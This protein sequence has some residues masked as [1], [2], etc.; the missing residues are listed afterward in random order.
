MKHFQ[1]QYTFGS[2]EATHSLI[3]TCSRRMRK[4]VNINSWLTLVFPQPRA[5]VRRQ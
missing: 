4:A 3:S 2:K 1:Y 5:D